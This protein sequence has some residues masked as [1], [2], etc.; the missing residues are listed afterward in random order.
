MNYSAIICVL[1]L[2]AFSMGSPIV[3]NTDNLPSLHQK[4]NATD[5]TNLGM[6]VEEEL[7]DNVFFSPSYV[8]KKKGDE[9]CVVVLSHGRATKV[10]IVKDGAVAKFLEEH[11]EMLKNFNKFIN[12][13]SHPKM[14]SQ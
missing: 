10:K 1:G 8:L 13:V 9:Y 4:Q 6:E 7:S 11:K 5:S 14:K 3:E 12:D 2:V